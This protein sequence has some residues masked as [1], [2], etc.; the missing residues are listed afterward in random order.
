MKKKYFLT[1]IG[2]FLVAFALVVTSFS[3]NSTCPFMTFQ[4]KLPEEAKRLK[5]IV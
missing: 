2:K 5:K 3:V 1:Q 4:P